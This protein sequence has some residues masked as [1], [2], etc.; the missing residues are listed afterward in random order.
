MEDGVQ[1]SWSCLVQALFMFMFKSCSNKPWGSSR[2]S[3][4]VL[5]IRNSYEPLQDHYGLDAKYVVWAKTHGHEV[6]CLYCIRG[7]WETTA[8]IFLI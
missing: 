8:F 7:S 2:L 3:L 1:A 4:G 6:A 5:L